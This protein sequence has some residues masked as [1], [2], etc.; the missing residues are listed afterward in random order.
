MRTN[1]VRAPSSPPTLLFASCMDWMESVGIRRGRVQKLSFERLFP[2][3]QNCLPHQGMTK[4]FSFFAN[5]VNFAQLHASLFIP[6][7][8]DED[9][10]S[11]CCTSSFCWHPLSKEERS[12]E[13]GSSS[14]SQQVM[15][16]TMPPL[17]LKSHCAK[18]RPWS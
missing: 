17:L 2:R 4:A 12:E 1:P 9:D 14:S 5:S 6:L 7:G 3:G 18:K 10:A 13:E 8:N 16:Q 15:P 11:S